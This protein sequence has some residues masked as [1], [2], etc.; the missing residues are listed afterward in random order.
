MPDLIM[1]T[2]IAAPTYASSDKPVVMKITADASTDA[3]RMASNIASAPDAVSAPDDAFLPC[4]L[5]NL[6]MIIFTITATPIIISDT[7]E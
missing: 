5:K 7:V 6:P 2:D 1:N 3:E 4:A